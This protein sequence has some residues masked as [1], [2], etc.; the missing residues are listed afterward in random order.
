MAGFLL[1]RVVVVAAVAYAG[2]LI[3]PLQ[4]G[5]APNVGLALLLAAVVVGFESRLRES[6]PTRVLGVLI[7]GV[8]GLAIARAIASGLFWANNGDRKVEFLHSFLLITLP[9][10]GMVLGAKNA[11]W[12]EP[13]RFFSLFHSASPQRRYKILDTSVIIDGR[14]SDVCDTGFI[15]GTLVILRFSQAQPRSPWAGHPAQD[16]KDQRRRGH[17]FRRR[18]SG[19]A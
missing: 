3:E 14:I 5:I 9:Y 7:G 18:L 12:L 15:D 1:A 10:L 17:D 19:S 16:S 8:I 13:V 2:A 11:E 6:P 4:G